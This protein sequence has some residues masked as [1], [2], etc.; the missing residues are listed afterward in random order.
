MGPSQG[1]ELLL[2]RFTVSP[3]P[4]VRAVPLSLP[5]PEAAP[6]SGKHELRT[7]L[8]FRMMRGFLNGRRFDTS[9]M[10][11]IAGDEWLPV[12]EASVWTFAN[13]GRGMPMPHPIHIHGVRFQVVE[14]NAGRVPQDLREGVIDAGFKDTFGIFPGER[15][16]VLLAPSEPGLFMYHCHNLEHEDGGMM[17]NCQFSKS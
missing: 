2:A 14:R 12:G 1:E 16:R 13:D 3:G 7:Q 10:M 11:A 5:E 9:D 4:R 15:V 8:A 17:R 6:R